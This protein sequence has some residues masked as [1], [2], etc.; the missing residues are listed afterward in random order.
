MAGYLVENDW[1]T[2]DYQNLRREGLEDGGGWTIENV[3]SG[4]NIYF[5]CLKKWMSQL[6]GPYENR[7]KQ[8]SI[9]PF[10]TILYKGKC[11]NER[12]SICSL[13]N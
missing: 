1:K 8:S 12:K 6:V 2:R 4:T 11:T 9:P 5:V 7:T 10:S 3:C 13:N